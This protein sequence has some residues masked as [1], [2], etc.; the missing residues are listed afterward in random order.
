MAARR[1]R[2]DDR[3]MRALT[4]LRALDAYEWA[5]LGEAVVNILSVS[6]R[7]RLVGLAP[8]LEESGRPSTR[9][10]VD[11]VSARRIAALVTASSRRMPI[12]A[13]CLVRS[14]ALNRMLR[15]RGIDSRLRIGVR[16]LEASRLDA[17]C[18]VE[19]DG[20]PLND[21]ADIASHYAAIGGALT[22]QAFAE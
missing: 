16:L 11:C 15:R 14:L 9:Q 20:V 17:H 7:L 13:T 1:G 12:R 18:W 10:A 4:K 3:L 22:A 2:L 19:L 5:V 6:V 21:V 8:L